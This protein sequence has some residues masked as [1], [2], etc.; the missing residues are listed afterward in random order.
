MS[1]V[2]LLNSNEQFVQYDKAIGINHFPAHFNSPS[3]ML[4]A[5]GAYALAAGADGF[6]ADF[7]VLHQCFGLS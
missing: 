2:G 5:T 6:E 1:D 3:G 7:L 4:K